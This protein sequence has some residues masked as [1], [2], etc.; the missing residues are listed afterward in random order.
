[1]SCLDGLIGDDFGCATRTG[2]LYLN[3]IGI[4]EDFIAAILN[5][6][7]QSTSSFMEDRRRHATAAI[8]A[9]LV[10][11]YADRI[12]QK[13][14]I[15][16][17]R[18][19]RYPEDEVLVTGDATYAQG[20]LIEVCTPASNTRLLVTT[21][22]FYGETTGPV[23]ATFHDLRDGTVLATETLTA[24]AGQVATLD[25]DLAF[26]CFREKKRI[27]VT[28]DQDVYYR[29]NI[30]GTGCKAC[31]NGGV[32]RGVM[33]ARPQRILNSDKKIG[34][35]LLPAQDT[36]GLSIIATVQCDP[37]A[38]IC[39]AKAAVALPLLYFM[40]WDIFTLA[41]N[42]YQRWGIQNMRKDDIASRAEQLGALY[43]EAMDNLYNTM[44]IPYDGVCFACNRR[45]SSGVLIP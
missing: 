42:N 15:D 34:A 4:T 44:P 30:T 31:A 29:A 41:L 20:I 22:E 3:D 13:T 32:D 25:V 43:N 45:T 8:P 38:W 17:D 6:S 1:M 28:T 40:G 5:K 27:L 2:R 35:N 18:I 9:S 36:G 39:E 24:V 37:Y 21:I 7:D 11:H 14:F 26:Q 33:K 10:G 12:I 19:G 16:R 23:V